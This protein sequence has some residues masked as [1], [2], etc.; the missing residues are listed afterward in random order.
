MT[1]EQH[2]TR[3]AWR[4]AMEAYRVAP[5]GERNRTRKARDEAATEVLRA[6]IEAR[7]E[8]KIGRAA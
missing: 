1:T 2:A 6:D 3:A 4:R 7:R 8:R 5:R